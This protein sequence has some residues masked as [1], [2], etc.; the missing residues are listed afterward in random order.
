MTEEMHF[1]NASGAS[2][3]QSRAINWGGV[4]PAQAEIQSI[5]SWRFVML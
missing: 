5:G 4:M 1:P 2:S 3:D